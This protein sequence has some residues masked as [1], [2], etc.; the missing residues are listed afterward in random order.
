MVMC[1][2]HDMLC[3]KDLQEQEVTQQKL[4]LGGQEICDEKPNVY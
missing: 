2:S 3:S 1:S 4:L